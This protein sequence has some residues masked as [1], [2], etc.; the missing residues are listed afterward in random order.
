MIPYLFA[1][2]HSL[3]TSCSTLSWY[4]IS[5]TPSFPVNILFDSFLIPYIF[6][7]LP[8]SKPYSPWLP[9]SLTTNYLTL[10][11]YRSR[12]QE[13]MI[14]SLNP[15][16]LFPHTLS[17]WLPNY[18]S[19]SCLTLSWYSISLNPSHPHNLI[20]WLPHSLITSYLT[21]FWYPISLTPWL[22]VNIL[23]DSFLIPYLF[24]SLTPWQPCSL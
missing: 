23:F 19:T 16:W 24:D 18:L 14:I 21:L 4:P 1:P 2:P 17:L 10:S 22:P 12:I 7:S 20:L 9:H 15:F 13:Q 3:S 6:D 5:L 11:W 8:P